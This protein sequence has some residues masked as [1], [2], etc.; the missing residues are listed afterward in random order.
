MAGE[1]EF[2]PILNNLTWADLIGR[3]FFKRITKKYFNKIITPKDIFLLAQKE[4]TN[5]LKIWRIYGNNIGLC[6]SHLISVINP[7]GLLMFCVF[8]HFSCFRL[9]R[10]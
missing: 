4:N 9:V 5:A 2:S 10:D 7:M 3:R 6:L 1:Y 8:G